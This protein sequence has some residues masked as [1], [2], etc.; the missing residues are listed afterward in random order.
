MF[1]TVLDQT[2]KFFGRG[3]VLAALVP[4]I[5]FV[6]TATLTIWGLDETREAVIAWTREESRQAI[7]EAVAILAGTYLLAYVLY[8]VRTAIHGLYQGHLP[9]RL[10]ALGAAGRAL[11]R[12][13][14]RA[15]R[16]ER[17]QLADEMNAPLWATRSDG[18]FTNAYSREALRAE[19]ARELVADANDRHAKLVDCVEAGERWRERSYAMILTDAHR[20][21]GR[22][23]K[24]GLPDDVQQATEDLITDIRNAQQK[25][26]V[27]RRAA[28]S[29]NAAAEQAW[30]DAHNALHG[31]YPRG[32]DSLEATALG[33]VMSA[34]ESRALERYGI[35]VSS[36]WPRLAHV[37]SD[38][39]RDRIEERN[40]YLDFTVLMSAL[41]SATAALA[42]VVAFAEGSRGAVTSGTLV[43]GALFTAWLFYRLAISAARAFVVQMEAAVDLFR[44]DLIDALWLERPATPSAERTLWREFRNFL[45]HDRPPDVS[46]RVPSKPE[47]DPV[48]RALAA[49]AR[50]GT[51]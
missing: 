5:L 16:A 22:A 34:M 31:S 36:L 43:A 19:A 7:V 21:Q 46:F 30:R 33:N 25:Y 48:R 13:R 35:D 40:I 10:R 9:R 20:L 32:E 50:T 17:R 39:V 24:D 1:G 44:L 4:A 8:G 26:V 51:A 2:V 23:H 38:D 11:A 47:N 27:L 18:R 45:A 12:R 3:F 41:A 49:R 6:V 28:V 37:T 42:L 14:F 29:I 15:L